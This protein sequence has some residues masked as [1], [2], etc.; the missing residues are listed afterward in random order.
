M[1]TNL[2][3]LPAEQDRREFR[4]VFNVSKT[5]CADLRVS[6]VRL[7]KTGRVDLHPLQIDRLRADA[8]TSIF[9]GSLG[10]RAVLCTSCAAILNPIRNFPV[11]QKTPQKGTHL[12]AITRAVLA[13]RRREV[14]QIR[15]VLREVSV[16]PTVIKLT[17]MKRKEGCTCR[18]ELLAEQYGYRSARVTISIS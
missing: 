2:N 11:K 14:E 9:S 10:S 5:S 4:D 8:L 12:D 18:H 7:H 13:V 1:N 16:S 17:L 15:A 3:V 6:I